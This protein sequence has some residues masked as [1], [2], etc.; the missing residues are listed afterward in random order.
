VPDIFELIDKRDVEGLRMFLSIEPSATGQRDPQGLSVLMRAFYRG[1]EIVALVRAA[2]PPLDEWDRILIG[3]SKDLPPHDAWS[4]DGF[5][6]LHIA[7]F[8]KNLA[9]VRAL[10]EAG[11]DPNV[12]AKAPFAKVTPLGTCAFVNAIDVAKELMAA[13]ADPT[14]PK[15][16]SPIDAAK[17]NKHDALL[18]ILEK[19]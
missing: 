5:T 16:S 1:P 8:A 7:A 9:A 13:G 3:E 6:P 19:R 11:A 18:A 2:D 14:I 12:I 4:P 17:H 10:L 15:G